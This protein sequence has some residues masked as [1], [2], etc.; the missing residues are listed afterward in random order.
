MPFVKF[1]QNSQKKGSLHKG[2]SNSFQ[3]VPRPCELI[4]DRPNL[5]PDTLLIPQ[6]PLTEKCEICEHDSVLTL[7]TYSVEVVQLGN[8]QRFGTLG[9]A[10]PK[11]I[12]LL[13]TFQ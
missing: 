2:G 9:Q 3:H 1:G 10:T 4:Y 5:L 7:L 11:T 12:Q 13:I 6:R 8:K